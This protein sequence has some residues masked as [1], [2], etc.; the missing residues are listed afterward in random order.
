[1]S[2]IDSMRGP[3]PGTDSTVTVAN[4]SPIELAVI[5]EVNFELA[6][7]YDEAAED[8][9][10]EAETRAGAANTARALR[11]RGEFFLIAAARL[12]SAPATPGRP[13]GVAPGFFYTGP[14]RRRRGRRTRMRRIDEGAYGPAAP[15]NRRVRHDRRQTDRRRAGFVIDARVSEAGA[16][17]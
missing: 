14:E 13:A 2:W 7:A 8:S 1:M 10:T 11:Q 16:D 3:R 12:R 15:A 17:R 9:T 4:L 6:R 5:A